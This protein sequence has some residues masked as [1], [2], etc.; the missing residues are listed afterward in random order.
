MSLLTVDSLSVRYGGVVLALENVSFEVPEG[1]C[2]GLL[3]ANGAGKTTILRTVSGLLA[4]HNGSI[5]SGSI[6]YEGRSIAGADASR[7]VSAGIAQV[8]EGRRVFRDLT[9]A[10]NLRTGAFAAAR[11]GR[12][13]EARAQVLELFPILAERLG[14]Q[15][16]YL[17]GGEQSMLSIARALMARPRLLLLDE[18]SLGLAPIIVRQIGEVLQR[19][20]EQGCALLLVDQSTALALQTTRHAYLLETGRIIHHDTTASLLGDARVRA[21]YLGTR[22]GEETVRE[23]LEEAAP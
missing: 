12:E 3:G 18:P 11:R 21:S 16:G 7:L 5:V 9:V 15:A 10:D 2:V 1:G 8:L 14:Q 4:F 6:T 17:S 22:A 20:N 19:I 23:L 13:E